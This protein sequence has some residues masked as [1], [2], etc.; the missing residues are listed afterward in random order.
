MNAVKKKK[1]FVLLFTFHP[2]K[3]AQDPISY[4]N[5]YSACRRYENAA[6]PSPDTCEWDLLR[7]HSE[8]LCV[9]VCVC[10]RVCQAL[11]EP[12]LLRCVSSCLLDLPARV[13]S[14]AC[15]LTSELSREVLGSKKGSIFNPAMVP[16]P[17]LHAAP[18]GPQPGDLGGPFRD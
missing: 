11:G 15:E 1:V 14:S 4:S 8:F 18:P 6:G 5:K 3:H 10:A 17:L 12:C 2:C 9:C 7:R 13:V 16:L